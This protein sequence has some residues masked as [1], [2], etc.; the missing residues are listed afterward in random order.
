MTEPSSTP[1]ARHYAGQSADER[2]AERRARLLAATRELVG[3]VGYAATTIEQICT[4]AGVSTRHFYLQYAGKEA[5]FVDL[6]DGITH[7]AFQH[8]A[9]SLQETEGQPLRRRIP[10]AM[11]AYLRPMLEDL[12]TARIAFV[13]VLGVSPQMEE[14][15]LQYREGLIGLIVAEGT[16]AVA[17]GEITDRDFRFAALAL[18]GAANAIIPDWAVRAD[19]QSI[20]RLQQQLSALAITLLAD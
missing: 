18:V 16:A 3:T 2:A 11:L 15:R 9:A 10:K 5:A 17:K 7:E 1:I 12:H 4:T 14:T 8:A 6:Y 20:A 19:R 13:E